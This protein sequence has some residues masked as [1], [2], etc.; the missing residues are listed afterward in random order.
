[1]STKLELL[2]SS[3]LKSLFVKSRIDNLS[4]D[5]GYVDTYP[6][7]E[8]YC[9]LYNKLNRPNDTI[10]WSSKSAAFVTTWDEG[11]TG[12]MGGAKP[13]PLWTFDFLAQSKAR[14]HETLVHCFESWYLS[15]EEVEC[16]RSSI[17][18]HHPEKAGLCHKK[19]LITFSKLHL[20]RQVVINLIFHLI[21]HS[22]RIQIIS[23]IHFDLDL[24]LV[25][26]CWRCHFLC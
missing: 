16:Y 9:K 21:T 13:L 8:E 12:I 7:K 2:F 5:Q 18:D 15:F 10:G 20:H 26:C 6:C 25:F 4:Y 22:I 17:L 19:Y 1:M 11:N 23:T 14:V 3:G 24:H